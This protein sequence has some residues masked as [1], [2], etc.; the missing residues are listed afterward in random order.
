MLVNIEMFFEGLTLKYNNIISYKIE[1]GVYIE[2]YDGT[3]TI[4]T[5]LNRN[6]SMIITDV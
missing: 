5:S 2:A 3:K 6:Y 4:I 1:H